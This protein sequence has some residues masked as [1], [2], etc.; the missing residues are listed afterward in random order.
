M[1]TYNK[2]ITDR[3]LVIMRSAGLSQTS[4]AKPALIMAF[5]VV[6]VG[7]ALSLYLLPTS[8]RMFRELQWDIRYNYSQILLREGAFNMVS[9]DVTVYVRERTADGEL[10]GILVHDVRK[11]NKPS[12]I[13][14][15]RGAVVD[16]EG[17]ARVVMFDGNR[18]EIDKKT[19]NLSILY[20]DKYVFDL[21]NKKTDGGIRYREARERMPLELLDIEK[22]N[23]MNKKDYGKFIVEGHNRFVS[24]LSALAFTL[25]GLAC[26][27]SGKH[28]PARP[29]APHYGGGPN[30]RLLTGRR[31]G[32][33]ESVRPGLAVGAI[34]VRECGAAHSCRLLVHAASSA[35]T[36]GPVA[37]P[38]WRRRPKRRTD[39]RLSSTLSLYIGPPSFC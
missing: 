2:L 7:Y 33:A 27:I 24:P 14:A 31:D 25:V 35:G 11:K 3:E 15:E 8:Y 21:E 26:L 18:Q 13:M 30:H 22:E 19:K 20:F 10:H 34:D 12:T 38:A 9:D 32:S 36:A 39:V 29:D 4:L 28:H 16:S 23:L 37:A 6:L 17:Y 1:F 5:A